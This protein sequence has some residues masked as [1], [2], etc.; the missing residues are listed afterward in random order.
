MYAIRGLMFPEVHSSETEC[1]TDGGL[2]FKGYIVYRQYTNFLWGH[3]T[4]TLRSIQLGS[5]DVGSHLD[6]SR[7]TLR[8]CSHSF[9]S[10]LVRIR[11]FTSVQMFFH[12]N[13]SQIDLTHSCEQSF[14]SIQLNVRFEKVSIILVQIDFRVIIFPHAQHVQYFHT[15][16]RHVST[17]KLY[18]YREVIYVFLC[19]RCA[20]RH[21]RNI[22]DCTRWF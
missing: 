21:R 3:C 4:F 2:L 17:E 10:I 12:L 20:W 11:A 19:G 9:R 8:R 13:R 1:I 18:F 14:R 22:D 6:R 16:K 5:I 7:F 15:E